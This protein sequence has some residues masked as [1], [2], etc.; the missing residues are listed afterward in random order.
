MR[1]YE[2][3]LPPFGIDAHFDSTYSIKY[4]SKRTWVRCRFLYK[5]I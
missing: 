1:S 5:T 3:Q 2:I 4:T